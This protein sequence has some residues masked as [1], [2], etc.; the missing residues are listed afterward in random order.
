[1]SSKKE[2]I[3]I[4]KANLQKKLNNYTERVVLETIEDLLKRPEFKD[5]CTC[6]QCLLDIASYALNRLP[7]KYIASSQGE[8]R[9]RVTEFE[10]Q[11]QVD[12][13]STVTRAIEIVSRDPRHQG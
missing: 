5:I 10:N 13:V 11:V 1:M 8:L 4:N 2:E 9:T 7:A 12:V 3:K 6:E